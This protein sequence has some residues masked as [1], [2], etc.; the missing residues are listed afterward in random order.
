MKTKI[1]MYKIQNKLD[2]KWRN[3]ILIDEKKNYLCGSDGYS[4]FYHN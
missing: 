1:K 2:K 4:Y 3:K